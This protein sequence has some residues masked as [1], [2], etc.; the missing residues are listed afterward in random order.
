MNHRGLTIFFSSSF[1][2]LL[3]LHLMPFPMI[4]VSLFQLVEFDHLI[5]AALPKAVNIYVQKFE[6]YDGSVGSAQS[7][8]DYKLKNDLL[9]L[10]KNLNRMQHMQIVNYLK[11]KSMI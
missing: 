9:L 8:G 7:K 11:K 5:K 3:F 6:K 10:F 4:H 1:T 2:V